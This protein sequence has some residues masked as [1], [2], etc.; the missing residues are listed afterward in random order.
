MLIIGAGGHAK[1]V[2]DIIINQ[3]KNI[4]FLD[5]TLSQPTTLF[6][7]FK[8]FNNIRLIPDTINKYVLGV[9]MPKLRKELSE[10]ACNEGLKRIGIRS[11]RSQYGNFDVKIHPTVDVMDFVSISSS[12][13]IGEGTLLNRFCNIHHDVRIGTNCEI[14]PGAHIL[15]RVKVGNNVFIGA[16]AI[17]LPNIIIADNACVGAGAVVT[18][19]VGKGVTIVG[20]PAIELKR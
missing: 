1:E 8:V 13:T 3:Y 10:V 18:K 7:Q 16:G 15:G 9:G 14:A 4:A 11:A 6:D 2:L 12:V 5:N 17:I 19:N 20:N